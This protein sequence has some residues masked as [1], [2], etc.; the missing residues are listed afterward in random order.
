MTEQGQCMLM[1]TV[2]RSHQLPADSTAKDFQ[3]SCGL[4]ICPTKMHREFHGM[5][6]HGRAAAYKPYIT[7]CNA[8]RRMQWCKA[9]HH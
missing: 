1:R 5:G 7:K 4:Q 8:K 6:F 9:R 2:R 3:T